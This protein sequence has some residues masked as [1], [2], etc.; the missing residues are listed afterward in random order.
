MNGPIQCQLETSSVQGADST[1]DQLPSTCASSGSTNQTACLLAIAGSRT[2]Q[3]LLLR[4]GVGVGEITDLTPM[5][6]SS[7][8][9]LA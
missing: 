6:M 2:A 7:P 1:F 3:G 8:A 4:R 5:P 9:T